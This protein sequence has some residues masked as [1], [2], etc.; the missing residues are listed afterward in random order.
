MTYTADQAREALM[1][2]VG[3]ALEQIAFALSCLGEAYELVDE[4]AADQLEEELFRP[5]RTAYARARRALSGFGQRHG[6]EPPPV[7]QSDSSGLHSND[8][9]V[10]LQRA[11]E[12]SEAGQTA[13]GELQDSMLPVE[14]G[15][16]ELRADLTEIRSLLSQ[17]AGRGNALLRT[18]GR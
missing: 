16:Q 18:L 2:D 4:R 11:I 3:R 13:L 10:Y 5:V 8:P 1:A 9:R 15:D 14:V 12:A 6:L 17:V 7:S